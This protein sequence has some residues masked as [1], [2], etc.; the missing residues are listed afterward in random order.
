M[1]DPV[2]NFSAG[3]A[4]LPRAVLERVRSELP[5]Y[6]GRGVSI[7]EQSHR[8][9]DYDAI[10]NGALERIRK[11]LVVPD[12]HDI[13]FL[14][15]G[16]SGMF[17][18]VPLNFLPAEESADYV[19]TGRW[20]D[21]ALSE[22]STVG[23]AR[24][25]GAGK[26]GDRYVRIPR[27][28]ALELDPNAAYVHITSNNTVVGSQ[29]H[30]FPNTGDI[31]LVADMSSDILSGPLDVA[32]F[33]LIYAGAQKNL[34]PAGVT[35]VIADRTWLA[36]GR[37]D[38]PQILQFRTHAKANSLF[39]T[40][41]TFAIYLLGYVMEWIEA[42]GGAEAMAARTREKQ[43]LVYAAIDEHPGFYETDIEPDSRSWMNVTFRGPNEELDQ[44][45]L[46]EAESRRMIGLKGHRSVGGIRASLYNAVEI[47]GV[48]RLV[49]LMRD[50]ARRNG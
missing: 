34:G 15:G 35:V 11:L 43:Q 39:N 50:F 12:S 17:A 44:H 3:P 46:S 6:R 41:P 31:P 28:D 24:S 32:R 21:R 9:A 36:N 18:L 27:F 16:A 26:D 14:Q 8:G 19:L 40:P 47:D 33:G 30:A 4:A 38:I 5:D 20:S 13:L 29:F 7:L 37:T 23:R 48:V 49:E 1:T 10:H 42:E 25:A 2:V 45:F 22:A